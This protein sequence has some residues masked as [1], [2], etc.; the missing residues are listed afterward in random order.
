[1]HDFR[2]GIRDRKLP[3][4]VGIQGTQVFW[5]PGK[6]PTPPPP[7]KKGMGRPATRWTSPQ[8]PPTALEIAREQRHRKV[9]WREGT[10]GPQT[11]RFAAVRVRCAH[12]HD[13]GK[14]PGDE[15]WLLSE[16]PEGEKQPTKLWLCTLGEK[17]SLKALVRL[18]KL[19][20][21]VE[22]DYEDMKDELGL[23]HYE[24]RQ[25]RGF[26]HHAALCAI[27]HAFLVIQRALFPPE[28]DEREVDAAEGASRAAALA[29]PTHRTLPALSPSRRAAPG[30]SGTAKERNK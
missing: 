21:R 13:R 17:V 24:G 30:R 10:R 14:P 1:M 28:Q 15:E 9:T 12:E 16:W 23:D 19:R 7:R 6:A 3:Y 20:W 22:R 26:H 2:Q 29:A 25:W 18:S 27:T 11:S 8:L 5:P 4:A